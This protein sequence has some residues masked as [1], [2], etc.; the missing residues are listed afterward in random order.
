MN[1]SFIVTNIIDE[2][3]FEDFMR[4]ALGED[5]RILPFSHTDEIW[6]KRHGDLFIIYGTDVVIDTMERIAHAYIKKK[7]EKNES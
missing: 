3:D 1:W 2:T 6:N 5:W 7:K 4:W